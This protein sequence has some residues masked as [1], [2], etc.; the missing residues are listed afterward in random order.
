[1]ELLLKEGR[2][3]Q[4]AD[5][6]DISPD[7]DEVKAFL[8]SE[9]VRQLRSDKELFNYFF[10]ALAESEE[11]WT[12]YYDEPTRKI[13]Y[14]YEEGLNLVSVLSEAVVEAP[15]TH[16]LALFAEIDLF[17]HWFPNVTEASVLKE[18]TDYRGMYRCQQTMPWPI[19]PRDMVFSATGFLDRE[20]LACL[21][22]L[23]SLAEDEEY[24]GARAPQTTEG[25]VRLDIKRG[26]HYFQAVDSRRTRYV[27]IFN[28]DPQL[29]C[30]PNWLMNFTMT[31]VCY[32]ML[33]LIQEKALQVPDNEYGERIKQRKKLY[34]A[35]GE[36]S[37]VVHQESAESG[38]EQ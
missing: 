32:Q 35:E 30:M 7:S 21:S 38:E 11:A 29:A 4:T 10:G 20:R 23:K 9:E 6:E 8:Q 31:K 15:L 13:R 27:T 37:Q 24:F 26:Y 16:V 3:L 19:W 36:K 17:K 1:M 14:K 5:Y 28:C 25:H 2:G 22:V 33:V 34:G 12:V 18:V